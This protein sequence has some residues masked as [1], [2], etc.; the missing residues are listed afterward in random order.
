MIPSEGPVR[1]RSLLLLPI[2][3]SAPLW[4]QD[5][6][7]TRVGW[8]DTVFAREPEAASAPAMD[9]E[10]S[11]T[12]RDGDFEL[13][14]VKTLD[15]GVGDGVAMQQGLQ[16]NFS[17]TLENGAKVEG[18]LRDQDLPVGDGGQSASLREMDWMWLRVSRDR[19]WAVVGDHVATFGEEGELHRLRR[20]Q[21]GVAIGLDNGTV[22]FE[23]SAGTSR[24]TWR[25]VE[26]EMTDG[27]S[28]GYDLGLSGTGLKVVPGSVEV[29]VNGRVLDESEF[30]V[31][32]MSGTIDFTGV[33]LPSSLDRVTVRFQQVDDEGAAD[34]GHFGVGVRLGAWEFASGLAWRTVSAPD[35][36]S[37]DSL[38]L[39]T[40]AAPPLGPEAVFHAQLR[41]PLGRGGLWEAEWAQSFAEMD[42]LGG[43][44]DS[45]CG[46]ALR[47]K[48]A[49]NP[50]SR[51]LRLSGDG[52]WS[53]RF[54]GWES[55]DD[56]YAF[57]SL[58]AMEADSLDRLVMAKQTA[59]LPLG[60]WS[61]FAG[62]D[63]LVGEE[64]RE[65]DTLGR[66]A[67]LGR[68][69]ARHRTASVE[70]ESYAEWG[71]WD[72]DGSPYL[73]R[74][75]AESRAEWTRGAVRPNMRVRADWW[76]ENGERRSRQTL[77]E[78]GWRVS[79]A[80]MQ[81]TA[82]GEAELRQLP[83][84][85]GWSDSLS[86]AALSQEWSMRLGE[87]ELSVDGAWQRVRA[88][89]GESDLS[90]AD[91]AWSTPLAGGGSLRASLGWGRSF[92]QPLVR[93]YRRVARG[94]GNAMYDSTSGRWIEGVDLGDWRFDG[95]V[96]DSL[97]ERRLNLSTRWG[98]AADL[99]LGPLT[100]LRR[101]ILRDLSLRAHAEWEGSDTTGNAA[102]RT[103]E[104]DELRTLSEGR[105]L[106][107]GALAWNREEDEASAELSAEALD[108]KVA[109]YGGG[110][111]AS[112]A[113]SLSAAKGWRRWAVDGSVSRLD[114]RRDDISWDG[115]SGTLSLRRRVA[116]LSVGPLASVSDF[117]GE[118]ASRPIRSTL[119]AP[120]A[121][122]V[123]KSA[124]GREFRAEYRAYRMYRGANAVPWEMS[125]GYRRG[126]THR[127][128][129]GL[130]LEIADAVSLDGGWVAQIRGDGFRQKLKLEG[131]GVF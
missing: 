26:L 108:S 74:W 102:W 10:P 119:V 16:L 92:A 94:A 120:G 76:R 55:P 47:W 67:T 30:F 44:C 116:S 36:A 42:S 93:S 56:A 1:R 78:A 75:R 98:A 49:T 39:D 53:S 110:D 37:A 40:A 12:K 113:L 129:L 114:E 118:D 77:A 18:E 115:W 29:V 101:G 70:Q 86:R 105:F 3:L 22:F 35:D 84:G 123:W 33:R 9:A 131:R 54:R 127:A 104:V 125:E 81:W 112:V 14:G 68:F 17:G 106:R 87:G 46:H 121:A 5:R 128:E 43:D 109:G 24:A 58:W 38:G 88:P 60:R 15:V 66:K 45:G 41:G 31:D 62:G 83:D 91:L 27:V 111:N 99:P 6:W 100:G 11:G 59:E 64:E 126:T 72:N 48:W 4:A 61:L 8:P 50:E 20:E 96:R 69:G 124:P 80:R 117:S 97:A 71:G 65:S 21:Q 28:E 95:W 51:L 107:G 19:N 90:S 79:L 25:S 2:L 73:E 7:E 52:R 130:T 122:A 23:G 85:D 34:M 63:F 82:R 103:P 89:S 13:H 32:A 57:F